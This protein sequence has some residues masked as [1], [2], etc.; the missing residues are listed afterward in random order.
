MSISCH[1]QYCK[2]QLV[3]TPTH[4][5]STIA[6]TSINSN[7]CKQH[8][9]ASTSINSNSCKQHYIASTSINSNS[10]KQHY[11]ASTSIRTRSRT[12]SSVC[13]CSVF[14][15]WFFGLHRCCSIC[16][17][18]SFMSTLVMD[19]L[20]LRPEQPPTAA[21]RTGRHSVTSLVMFRQISS[22]M[23][24]LEIYTLHMSQENQRY[25]MVV[26]AVTI[27]V[28]ELQKT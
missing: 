28:Y 16:C 22:A 4:V 20:S 17:C 9:I 6:S 25:S 23:Q 7:S 26:V 3:T 10:C 5:S 1:S 24:Q 27:R 2:V 15:R 11:I 14:S 8:Y 13:S 12:S 19:V 18:I 21:H